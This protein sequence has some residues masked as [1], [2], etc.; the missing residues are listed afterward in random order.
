M[1]LAKA[2]KRLIAQDLFYG[3]FLLN[4]NKKFTTLVDTLAVSIEGINFYLLINED[5]WKSLT[6]LEQ[7]AVLK[8]EV[9][10]LCLNHLEISSLFSDSELYNI[11]A[12]IEVNQYIEN[13]PKGACTLQTYQNF[14][15][16]STQTLKERQGSKYYYEHLKRNLNSQQLQ[17]FINKF[18]NGIDSHSLW[19]E[20]NK[21]SN[22]HKQLVD[23][24]L[25]EVLRSTAQSVIKN[26]GTIPGELIEVVD[27]LFKIKPN[28]FNW[29]AY[30]RRMIGNS[31][32]TYTKK[33]KRKESKRFDFADGI[34]VRRKHK[35]LVAIDTSGSV[36]HDEL[37]EFFSEIYY[38]YKSGV[39]VTVAECDVRIGRIYHYKGVF[40]GKITGRGGTEYD[41][42]IDYY[43]EHPEF[44]TCIYFT[45]GECPASHLK[46]HGNMIWIISSCG[47]PYDKF[48]GKI[49][50]I[51]K[52]Q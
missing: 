30:F 43:N 12:D 28:V 52:Q 17:D 45:D 39:S 49:I 35:I 32:A 46:P 37:N 4:V 3:T 34:K 38:I 13:L 24:Q 25:K 29:K 33:T 19:K 21:L 14:D 27:E 23:N 41:P 47:K 40:D 51:P 8:H 48:P 31:F 1:D 20:Y 9:L 16:T 50:Q 36:S 44:T 42:V 18:A 6:D 26:R 2:C 11:A 7:I 10:H 22:A 5:F 15:V